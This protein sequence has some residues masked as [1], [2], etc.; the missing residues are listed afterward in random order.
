MKRYAL[1]ALLVVLL[2]AAL[3]TIG[4]LYGRRAPVP[5][6]PGT[7]STVTTIGGGW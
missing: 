7:P 2:L 6:D 5:M 4:A 1:L 3:V